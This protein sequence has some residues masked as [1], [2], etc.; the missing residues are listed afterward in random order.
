MKYDLKALKGHRITSTEL[1]QSRAPSQSPAVV[2]KSRTIQLGCKS[3]SGLPSRSIDTHSWNI[4]EGR[5]H[6]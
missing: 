5:I 4:A 2:Q 6:G 1:R 3:T